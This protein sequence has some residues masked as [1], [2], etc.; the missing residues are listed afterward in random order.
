MGKVTPLLERSA[1]WPHGQVETLLS[2]QNQWER[3]GPLEEEAWITLGKLL[4]FCC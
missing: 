2:S 3:T 1:I 4:S